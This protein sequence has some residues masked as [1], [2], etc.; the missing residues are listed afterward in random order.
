MKR[1]LLWTFAALL[2]LGGVDDARAEPQELVTLMEGDL[3]SFGTGA[4]RVAGYGEVALYLDTTFAPE[5]CHGNVSVQ[6]QY[7]M[8][9]ATRWATSGQVMAMP[10]GPQVARFQVQGTELGLSVSARGVPASCGAHY[11][12]TVVGVK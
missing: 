3:S 1:G 2:F 12:Y 9:S 10:R 8:G 5:E 6:L 11:K 7:R 4:I